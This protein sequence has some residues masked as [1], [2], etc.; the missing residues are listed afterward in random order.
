MFRYHQLLCCWS[1]DDCLVCA[2]TGEVHCKISQSCA[3]KATGVFERIYLWGLYTTQLFE[4]GHYLLFFL[5]LLLA[6][7]KQHPEMVFDSIDES[8]LCS[9]V[10]LCCVWSIEFVFHCCRLLWPL[11]TVALDNSFRYQVLCIVFHQTLLSISGYYRCACSSTDCR[12]Y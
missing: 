11:S 9:E 12:S 5:Q 8:D 3:N 6:V 2:S 1:S 7:L 10:S 4:L